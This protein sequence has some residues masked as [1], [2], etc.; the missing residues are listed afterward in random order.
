MEIY[1][2]FD[3][4]AFF[5]FLI[6]TIVSFGMSDLYS[7]ICEKKCWH[8]YGMFY[9]VM[10]VICLLVLVLLIIIGIKTA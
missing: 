4:V 6:C 10:T 2:V 9:G 8:N 3:L 1:F 5:A 7:D